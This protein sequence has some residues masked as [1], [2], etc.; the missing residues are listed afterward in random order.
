MAAE[1][2]AAPEVQLCAARGSAQC[3][4]AHHLQHNAAAAPAAVCYQPWPPMAAPTLALGAVAELTQN[5]LR[6]TRI[7]RGMSSTR[8]VLQHMPLPA[9]SRQQACCPCNSRDLWRLACILLHND[10][11][12]LMTILSRPY[13][14][15]LAAACQSWKP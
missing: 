15:S 6:R 9:R 13:P 12:A 5:S 3:S 14:R 2:V 1:E 10:W 8:H 11:L 7:V 4:A